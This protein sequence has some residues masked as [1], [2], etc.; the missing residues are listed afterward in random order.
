M[1]DIGRAVLA[2]AGI[3][4]TPAGAASAR[5][6]LSQPSFEAGQ[7]Y[8]AFFKVEQGCDGSP[9]IA[10]NVQIPADVIVL[11]T[12]SKP[13]W[14]VSAKRDKGRV[15]DVTWRG[16]L[17]AKDAD[18]F[19]LFVKLPAKPGA[20]YFPVLQQ[21]EKSEIRWSDIPAPGQAPRDIAH[22]APV[23]RLIAAAQPATS[24]SHYMAGDIMIE[25]PWAPA[26]PRGAATAVAYMTI[27]NHGT[28]ADTLLGGTSPV[29]KLDIHQ[30]SM[31]NGIMSMRPVPGG[32]TLPPGSTI[33]LNAQGY[34]FMLSGLKAPLTEGARVPATLIFAKAGQVP[35]ELSVAAIGARAPA[36]AAAPAGSMPGMPGMTH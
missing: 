19:G 17:A 1:R 13:G 32:V 29:G 28:S 22:P 4:L 3:I 8:A 10:L 16:K 9:T 35:V 33:T 34:H 6:A 11:D 15:T 24:T 18:Q 14:A 20:L 12:P 5:I 36:G 30:M 31:A 23:L 2:A 21:C 26:T 7:N 25:Q 27:M